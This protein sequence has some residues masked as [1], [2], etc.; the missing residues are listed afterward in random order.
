MQIIGFS[1]TD[2]V[3]FWCRRK[4]FGTQ[5]RGYKV[6]LLYKKLYMYATEHLGNRLVIRR[7]WF[8]NI[9]MLLLDCLKLF[10]IFELFFASQ[11][12]RLVTLMSFHI[13]VQFTIFIFMSKGNLYSWSL[14]HFFQ[15]NFLK[16][17]MNIF[18]LS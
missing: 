1:A 16:Q 14:K 2:W 12:K 5:W 7:V 18:W 15:V 9:N 10:I 8:W 17:I 13:T 3:I 4:I 11:Q 6:C